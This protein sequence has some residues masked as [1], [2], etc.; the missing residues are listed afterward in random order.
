M[1]E[2]IKGSNLYIQQ[3]GYKKKNNLNNLQELYQRW[4]KG[5]IYKS[6]I[7]RWHKGIN[8]EFMSKNL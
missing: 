5:I 1:S 3:R 7:N 8:Q 6:C 2:I 4:H